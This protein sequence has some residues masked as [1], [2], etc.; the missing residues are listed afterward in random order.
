MQTWGQGTER[1]TNRRTK[2]SYRQL[3]LVINKLRQV[4][5]SFTAEDSSK[6]KQHSPSQGLIMF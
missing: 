4:Y 5:G 2:G 6:I 1:Q 3:S